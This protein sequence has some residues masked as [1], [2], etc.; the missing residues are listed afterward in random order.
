MGYTRKSNRVCGE[1]DNILVFQARYKGKEIVATDDDEQPTRPDEA[2]F[3]RQGSF[4][5]MDLPAEL[6][7]YIYQ[8]LL[9]YDKVLKFRVK[10]FHQV[11]RIHPITN[12]KLWS[13]QWQ[14][15][16]SSSRTLFPTAQNTSQHQNGAYH[17]DFHYDFN[18]SNVEQKN[19]LQTQLF[20]VSKEVSK[21][22]RAVLYGSNTYEFD[23]TSYRHF[24]IS[25][26]SPHIFGPFGTPD[27]LPLLRNLRSIHLE[28][29]INGITHW[30]VKRQRARLEYFISVLKEHS[31]DADTRSLLQKMTVHLGPFRHR[32]PRL[33][34][35]I[36][37]VPF[38]PNLSTDRYMFG[39]E[40]LA[41]LRGI[42]DVE[43]TGV[44]DWYAQ[45][46]Q[47]CIQGKGGEVEET[48]WPEVKKKKVKKTAWG[49]V[50]SSKKTV[51][52]STRKWWQPMLNWIEYAE[53]NGVEVPMGVERYWMDEE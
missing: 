50:K 26:K 38:P 24:P 40:S 47:L 29:S 43:I 45:C 8:F 44:P 48:E 22:A 11:K 33:R 25:L 34:C 9:P 27:H 30:V 39:L 15:E 10:P 12:A 7:I 32:R 53:R 14:L 46:L 51:M 4:R 28:V 41:A 2:P 5:L 49:Q 3:V 19:E 37:R 6:R 20:L 31:D 16:V 1:L 21:E 13:P 17:N 35:S 36:P 52:V 23:I 18:G 42:A